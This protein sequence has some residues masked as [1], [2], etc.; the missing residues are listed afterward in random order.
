MQPGQ[1]TGGFCSKAGLVH[2][3][4]GIVSGVTAEHNVWDCNR[5]QE[6][7]YSS[8]QVVARLPIRHLTEGLSRYEAQEL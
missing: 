6:A 1:G 5:T 8:A 4:K 7:D 3:S 2:S